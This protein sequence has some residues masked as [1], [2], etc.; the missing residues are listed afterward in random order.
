MPYEITA[1]Q[2]RQSA[3]RAPLRLASVDELLRAFAGQGS[4]HGRTFQIIQQIKAMACWQT[5]VRYERQQGRETAGLSHA[6]AA[7]RARRLRC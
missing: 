2:Q 5:A 1:R 6:K 4:M 3:G 7:E